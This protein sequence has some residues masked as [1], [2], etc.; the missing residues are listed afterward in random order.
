MDFPKIELNLLQVEEVVV[1]ELE[2]ILRDGGNGW[3]GP[4]VRKAAYVLWDYYVQ[5][6]R[7]QVQ[8]ARN[9]KWAELE[10]DEDDS[11]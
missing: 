11:E 5:Y 1:Q 7:K 3:E 10:D 4:E 2:S 9:P 6:D 8:L